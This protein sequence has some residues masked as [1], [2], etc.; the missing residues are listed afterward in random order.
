MFWNFLVHRQMLIQGWFGFLQFLSPL[1]CFLTEEAHNCKSSMHT[2]ALSSW[3]FQWSFNCHINFTYS[4]FLLFL[5][6]TEWYFQTVILHNLEVFYDNDSWGVTNFLTADLNMNANLYSNFI[7]QLETPKLVLFKSKS[8]MEVL[9][10]NQVHHE[11]QAFFHH[12][13]LYLISVIVTE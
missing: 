8:F 4:I 6:W 7:L 2:F 12:H 13:H 3:C 11:F 9:V 5:L 1:K 10:Q